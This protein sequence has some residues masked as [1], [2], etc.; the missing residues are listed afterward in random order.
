[1]THRDRPHIIGFEAQPPEGSYY[2]MAHYGEAAKR[3]GYPGRREDDTESA[4]LAFAR[5]LAAEKKVATVP[6]SSFYGRP[7]LGEDLIR[8]AFPKQIETL[9]RVAGQLG[10]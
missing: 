2:V 7:G 8:F 10:V 9:D 1:V 4:D 6:G 5:W 3:L